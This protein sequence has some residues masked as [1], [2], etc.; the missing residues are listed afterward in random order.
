MN[1]VW[2][3]P[4]EMLVDQTVDMPAGA[5]LLHAAVQRP[6]AWNLVVWALVDPDAPTVARRVSVVGTGVP[7]TVGGVHVS[8]FTVGDLVFHVLDL[9]ENPVPGE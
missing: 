6:R 5:V 7:T 4:L 8:T 1:V 3:F 2:K 9:G